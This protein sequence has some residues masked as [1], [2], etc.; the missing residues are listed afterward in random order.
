MTAVA[1]STYARYIGRVGALA[2]ALGVGAAVATGQGF[3][4]GVARAET[5]TE[6][7]ASSDNPSADADNPPASA[8]Q[9]PP[10]PNPP[11]ETKPSP[12]TGSP[13]NNPAA[14]TTK[15][16]TDGTVDTSFNDTGQAT[17]DKDK[18]DVVKPIDTTPPATTP[19][20]GSAPSVPSVNPPVVPEKSPLV[21][22]NSSPH[23]NSEPTGTPNTATDPSPAG[24]LS[25]DSN[26]TVIEHD[27]SGQRTQARLSFASQ[28][29]QPAAAASMMMTTAAT[30]QGTP[31]P[32]P[33][34]RQ[35][36]G[37]VEAL[38]G[39][40]GVAVNIVTTV[41]AALL[42][43]FLAP[44]PAAPAP[45]TL[46]FVVLAWVQREVRRTF[47]NQT[48]DAVSDT[49]TTSEDTGITIP[50]L[51]N[52]TDPDTDD[53]ITVTD[54]AQA[55]NGTVALNPNGTFTYTPNANFNGT[56][57]FT[58]T[59]SDAA[60]PWHVHGLLGFLTGGGHTDTATVNIT[61]TGVNDNPVAGSDSFAVGED[62]A[63]TINPAD[64]LAN[65]SDVDNPHSALTVS[66][67]TG[68]AGGG[69]VVSN[70]VGGFTYTPPASAQSLAA[71]QTQTDTLTYTVSDGAGG[72]A[73]G[74]INVTITGAN[75][76]PVAGPDGFTVSEDAT[77]TINPAD[78][79]ANDS[80]AESPHS[81]LTVTAV[82]GSAGGGSVV[83][84]GLGGFT[85]TPPASAQSLAAGQT[86]TDTLTYT[87]SDGAGGT[88]F[89]TINVTITGAND[90]P[91]AG[92]DSFA[93]GEDGTHTIDPADLLANDS[94]VDNAHSAL[95]VSAVTGSAGGGS[96]VS[97]GL[98]GFTYTPPASA[99]SLG[100]GQTQTDTLIYTVSDGAGGTA[101]GTINVT[102][103]GANDNP[104]A[105]ADSFT[106]SEDATH[107]IDPADLLV[108]DSDAESPH[109]AL[110]VISI[111]GS[112]SGGSF[113]YMP[114][115]SAQSLGAG[116]T[117]TDTLHYVV[118]DG[119][120]G[121]AIGTIN[122]TITGANDNPVA[123]ADSFTVGKD[124]THTIDPADL[125]VNDSDVDN[126]HSALTVTA[127]TGTAG[128]GSVVP[129]GAGGYTYTPPASAQSLAA[130]QTQTDTLTYTVSDGAGGTATGSID[131][132]ITGAADITITVGSPTITNPKTEERTYPVTIT[133]LDL[134]TLTLAGTPQHG[135]FVD[136]MDGTFSYK[137]DRTFV[138]T[139]EPR[140][141]V[142][143]GTTA[144]DTF[145]VTATDASGKTAT[146]EVNATIS[147]INDKPFTNLV[148]DD[149]AADD[150]VVTGHLSY[151]DMNG[152][153]V[154][155][156][157]LPHLDNPSKGTL[158]Y[159]QA[160][161]FFK[162]TPNQAA[163]T[164]AN[165]GLFNDYQVG[166]T[167]T[168]TDGFPRTGVLN[169]VISLS[170]LPLVSEV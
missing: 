101:F 152:D 103:T 35:P 94:D 102:I 33:L 111:T 43:P 17:D 145:T 70:G 118:S 59:V 83:S 100:A 85:Y 91:V 131:V 115:A 158:E 72:T 88:A 26:P 36:S 137:P 157:A 160:T 66:A 53:V 9:T 135:T 114:P 44:G 52:D 104:V 78:L 142:P 170:I 93:V 134:A 167:L 77:H 48:P 106:V 2:V 143:K 4:V 75:D 15:L 32:A 64:L 164:A 153:P 24:L 61:V 39:I 11:T 127:V 161:G 146:A 47:F 12:G 123:A 125:L 28:D 34:V 73:T 87:V 65:D 133:G 63:H 16:G 6:S 38:L 140:P 58:Y 150:P 112:A 14:P 156:V 7:G 56:D 84:N 71:G 51:A 82:T 68:T 113:T 5:G 45:P 30:T 31:A 69:S 40:P 8:D 55:A 109:S 122:V 92:S 20:Q 166:M 107:T 90:N 67:V 46:F 96:V 168:V 29:V 144:T 159:D 89:G 120:G 97:N 76:N 54:Y 117:Q 57:S 98:G 41:V 13:T 27:N 149:K 99:Q 139:L 116:Q 130:G 25:G 81:A 163:R 74:T 105:A 147:F 10:S 19:P 165:S 60:S 151:T 80:D 86:Q 23:G 3:G 155:W 50:T 1:M 42:S 169:T 138:K 37:P 108:N 132:T 129:N 62:A 95:T 21:S 126:A 124:A 141:G 154:T 49:V 162:F 136:N 79:L 128:G 110:T 148:F 119:A 121:I 18:S 22:E